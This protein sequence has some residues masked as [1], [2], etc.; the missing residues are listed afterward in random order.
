MLRPLVR[1]RRRIAT[2]SQPPSFLQHIR[3]YRLGFVAVVSCALFPKVAHSFTVVQPIPR[4][5]S[6]VSTNYP[7]LYST[8]TSLSA[9]GR[10]GRT[11]KSSGSGSKMRGVKKENLP[12]KVCVVCHRPFTWRKKWEKVW[13]EVSTCS[14]SCNRKRRE[15][16]RRENRKEENEAVETMGDQ[17]RGL[18]IGLTDKYENEEEE[19]A[20]FDGQDAND[21]SDNDTESADARRK[22]ERKAAKKARKSAR[23]AER[24][25]RGDPTAG[26]KQC[27]QCGKSVDLLVRCQYTRGAVESGGW[28]AANAGM[29][30]AGASSMVTPTTLSIATGGFGR[31]GGRRSR[32]SYTLYKPIVNFPV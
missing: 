17:I 32:H 13:D 29:G 26:Q 24:E 14:K 15:K 4:P 8:S 22:A 20:V 27:D 11:G 21:A 12:Q 28:C 30:P 3:R 6:V 10:G 7:S 2:I 25:G 5:L 19:E 18:D 16:N 1:G 9:R 23:R 31:I